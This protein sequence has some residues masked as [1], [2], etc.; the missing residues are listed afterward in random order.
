[1]CKFKGGRNLL[2]GKREPSSN[3]EFFFLRHAVPQCPFLLSTSLNYEFRCTAMFIASKHPLC[4]APLV[5]LVYT[6]PE[7]IVG[8]VSAKVHE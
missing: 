5:V 2:F 6:I 8:F 7:W 1:M 3:L 4:V